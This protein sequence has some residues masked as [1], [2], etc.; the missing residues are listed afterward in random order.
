MPDR[1]LWA[2]AAA[3]KYSIGMGKGLYACLDFGTSKCVMGTHLT[4]E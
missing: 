2:L 4:A 3:F 1:A